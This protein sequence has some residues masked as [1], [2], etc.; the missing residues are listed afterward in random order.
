V[1]ASTK[2]GQMS[3]VRWWNYD[4]VVTSSFSARTSY[5]A[6]LSEF[7]PTEEDDTVD[8]R[9]HRPGSKPDCLRETGNVQIMLVI[10][11]RQSQVLSDQEERQAFVIRQEGSLQALSSCVLAKKDLISR[12]SRHQ[13][14]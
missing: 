6:A 7:L 10:S 12:K 9:F 1:V 14:K 5:I 8:S 13:L 11:Q 4:V 3:I 2:C